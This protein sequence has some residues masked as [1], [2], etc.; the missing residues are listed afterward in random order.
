MSWYTRLK[1]AMPMK[2]LEDLPPGYSIVTRPGRFEALF[3]ITC[4]DPTKAVKNMGKTLGYIDIVN[5]DSNRWYV[6][7][8]QAQHGYGPLLYD[9]AM[10]F[11]TQ[12]G[13]FLTSMENSQILEEGPS[14]KRVEWTSDDAK[15][16]WKHYK[17]RKDVQ[18]VDI[19]NGLKGYQK[20][21]DIL[22]RINNEQLVSQP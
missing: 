1:Q 19:G 11:V 20:Q 16:V 4:T 9:V 17:F 2:Q 5:S 18:P 21:P 14:A 22:N 10:E 12:K 7:D 15:G 6:A 3:Q 8:V 13:G